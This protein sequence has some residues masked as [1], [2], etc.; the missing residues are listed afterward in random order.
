MSDYW[1]PL[2]DNTIVIETR[3]ACRGY[4]RDSGSRR[5]LAVAKPLVFA[6]DYLWTHQQSLLDYLST[7]YG[8]CSLD[9][10]GGSYGWPVRYRQIEDYAGLN[11]TTLAEYIAAFQKGGVR[12]P[13]LRH[14]SLNRALPGVRRH[15]QEPRQFRPN[16]V[17]HPRLDRL[18]GPELFIGQSG[19]VFGNVHQDQAGVHVGFVQLQGAKEV[20]LFPPENGPYLYRFAGRQFPFEL[21]NSAVH[22]ADL[23]N[24]ERFPSLRHASPQRIVLQ[25]GQAMLLPSDW[26]HTTRNLSDS[27]SYNVRIINSSNAGRALWRHLLGVPR[28]VAQQ[29]D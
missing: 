5:S 28:W 24:F 6:C 15:L 3:H 12:L 2:E 27:V 17:Q 14:L 7:E 23:D 22:Y 21:R 4:Q 10:L 8:H 1:Q 16:W 11:I 20:V 9:S 13:Y 19:T 18:G 25:A 29:W 26:W